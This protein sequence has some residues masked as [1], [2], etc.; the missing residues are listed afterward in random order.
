MKFCH[1]KKIKNMKRKSLAAIAMAFATMGMGAVPMTVPTDQVQNL[2]QSQKHNEGV[3]GPTNIVRRGP[4]T[5]LNPAG[6]DYNNYFGT[7]GR[8]PKEFGQWLQATGRQKWVK[9]R[10]H[11]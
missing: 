7:E 10:N 4:V 8:S 1:H 3:Q 11:K 6:L 2:N 5:P 9:S